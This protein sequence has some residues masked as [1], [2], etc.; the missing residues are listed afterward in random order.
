MLAVA[1]M[2]QQRMIWY[3]SL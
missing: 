3:K 1:T 2:L